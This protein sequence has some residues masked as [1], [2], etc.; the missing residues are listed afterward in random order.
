MYFV[1]TSHDRGSRGMTERGRDGE[2]ERGRE[3]ETVGEKT[4]HEKELRK[5]PVE[6][7]VVF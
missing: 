3:G 2:R 6:T 1:A 5:P 7:Q 4:S